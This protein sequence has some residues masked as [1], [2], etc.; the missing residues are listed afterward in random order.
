MSLYGLPVTANLLVSSEQRDIRQNINAFSVTLDPD[1]IKRIV[2]QRATTML[3]AYAR[4]EAGELLDR[5]DS[6]KD[7]LSTYDPEKLKELE[8]YRKIQ[9]MRELANGDITNYSSAC[10]KWA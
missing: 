4:S 8:Q 3:E 5:Y 9:E 10:R 1:A 6:I 7:S 2:A